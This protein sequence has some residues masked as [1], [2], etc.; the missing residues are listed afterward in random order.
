QGDK[1]LL[2]DFG[3]AKVVDTSRTMIGTQWYAA[4]V[5][6]LVELE[7]AKERPPWGVY[8]QQWHQELQTHLNQHAPH[9]ASMLADA[10]DQ[11]PTARWLLDRFFSPPHAPLQTAQTNVIW[12]SLGVSSSANQA[13]RTTMIYSAAPT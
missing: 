5:E 8:W 13:N 1:F 3:I 7:D 10:A 11:R 2:T 12:T 4:P 6:C 9:Y